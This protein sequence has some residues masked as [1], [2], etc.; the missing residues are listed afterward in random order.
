M[1]LKSQGNIERFLNRWELIGASV[2]L[3]LLIGIILLAAWQ[4]TVSP[5]WLIHHQIFG[6]LCFLFIAITSIHGIMWGMLIQTFIIFPVSVKRFLSNS[7]RMVR[8]LHMMTGLLGLGLAILHGLPYLNATLSFDLITT[9]G[10]LAFVM[11][12][13]LALDG[14]GL[15]VSPFLNRKT[16]RWVAIFFL[17]CLFTHL[18]FILM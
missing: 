13:I 3:Y 8:P 16:H 17:I 6:W 14:I 2:S 10:I 7:I 5:E 1:L 15:M 18:Y 9:S 4:F 11:L 12:I